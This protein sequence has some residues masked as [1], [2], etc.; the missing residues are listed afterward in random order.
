VSEP[1]GWNV[2]YG[3]GETMRFD[4]FEPNEE[5]LAPVASAFADEV[6]AF[7]GQRE[8]GGTLTP[9]MIGRALDDLW[10]GRWNAGPPTLYPDEYLAQLARPLCGALLFPL[11]P[12][13]PVPVEPVH[14]LDVPY[15][16]PVQGPQPAACALDEGHRTGWHWDGR[17]TWFR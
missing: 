17:G 11:P 2:Y 5:A 10:A 1:I 8:Q 13:A 12:R 7:T 3:N 15:F 14:P 16:A 4:H 9:K 6:E